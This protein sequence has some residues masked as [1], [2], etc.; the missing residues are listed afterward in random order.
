MPEEILLVLMLAGA[1]AL[2]YSLPIGAAIC[3]LIAIVISSYRQ[4]IRA[5]PKGGGAYLVTKDNLGTLPGLVAGAALMTDYVLTVAVSVA[6]GVA[7]V[8]SAV[9]AL[10]PFRVLLCVA[11]VVL[12][13]LAN[14]RGIRES[15]KLFA[16]PTYLFIVSLGAMGIY[17]TL[18]AIFNF[19]P[20]A[21]YQP[22]PP[23]LEGVGLFLILRAFSSGCAALTGV[24]AVSDGVTAFK[25]PEAQNARV[26][27][28]WLGGILVV[29][30]MGIT[31][32]AYDFGIRPQEEQTVM[33]QLGRHLFGTPIYYGSRCH[34]A[35][36]LLPHRVRRLPRCTSFARP[37]L[38]RQFGT[39]GI[40]WCSQRHPHP[41][42]SPS[43]LISSA[44]T[45]CLIALCRGVF[46]RSLSRSGMVRR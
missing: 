30:F 24:E 37:L 2:S 15:G 10:F 9:P 41:A 33:S 6:A 38:P 31:F 1:V 8:T 43:P 23:G 22:H 34:N 44:A 46:R 35:H 17:G 3:V 11:A 32:L 7:A 14:L 19:V 39:Q 4:T 27:L 16:A 26:V 18:G 20:E 28:A 25:P 13:S 36:L 12:I 40:A 21:P 29:L 45:P 5:Y 42:A